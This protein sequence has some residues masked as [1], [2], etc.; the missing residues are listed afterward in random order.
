MPTEKG[1]NIDVQHYRTIFI[2]DVHLGTKGCQADRLLG[3][4][5]RHTCDQL[6][7]VGD[8]IDGWQIKSNFYWPESHMEVVREILRH[9]KLNTSVT[10]VT[11]NH[12]EFLR[13]YSNAEFGAL[14][15]VDTA[16]HETA[17]GRKLLV[18]HGDQFDVVTRYHKWVAVLGDI[19]YSI[20]LGLNNWLNWWRERFGYDHWS[21]SAWVKGKVKSAVNYLSNF[22]TAVVKECQRQKYDGVICGHIHHAEHRAFDDVEYYNCG[23]WVESC[24]ALLEDESGK[25]T[26][27]K[28]TPPKSN[29]TKIRVRKLRSFSR[30]R[31]AA[32]ASNDRTYR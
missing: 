10:Y 17:D 19:G 32:A 2:S 18:I 11:G 30:A 4:L 3:F 12:D 31:R 26:V 23:D 28:D 7:L 1:P 15:L 21:L 22:E 16:T 8:I 24:T 9:A 6:Y 20:L 27:Y 25:I 14:R 13:K 29:I 5:Q